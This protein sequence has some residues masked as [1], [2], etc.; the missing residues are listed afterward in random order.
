MIL[1]ISHSSTIIPADMRKTISISREEP[2]KEILHMAD[3]W[4]E[5]LFNNETEISTAFN[6]VEGG[7]II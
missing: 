3:L 4:T 2:I 1:H 7:K 5:G 6:Y